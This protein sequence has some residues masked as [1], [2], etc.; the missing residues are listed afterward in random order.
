LLWQ[1]GSIYYEEVREAVK[2]SGLGNVQVH[3]FISRMERAYY[4]ADTIVSR[5]GAITISEL[6]LIG[7]PA[8]LVPSPNVAEDHQTRNAAALVDKQAAWMVSDREA[9]EK[10]VDT[11]LQLMQNKEK[12]N[13]LS[14]QIKKLG[15]SD[16]AER[17][18]DEV[19]KLVN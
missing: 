1:C 6:C 5:A 15:I 4:I 2:K 12:Q 16:A 17:I 7:K 10:L 11:M 14:K 19:L 8:I 18:A 3:P 9:P 13:Q